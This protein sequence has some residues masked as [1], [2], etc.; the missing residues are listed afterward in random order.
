MDRSEKWKNYRFWKTNEKKRFKIVRKNS[1]KTIVFTDEQFYWK[2]SQKMNEIYIL[3]TNEINIFWTRTMNKRNE[4]GRTRPSLW[5]YT[6]GLRTRPS[7]W[8]YTPGLRPWQT[9]SQ[10]WDYFITEHPKCVHFSIKEVGFQIL[11]SVLEL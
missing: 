8:I 1:K 5:I 3:R 11:L 6:P 2:M 4:K 9:I 10:T 7:L